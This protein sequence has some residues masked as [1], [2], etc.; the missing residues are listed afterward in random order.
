ML[1]Q[2]PSCR[3][4]YR[5]DDNAVKIPN[6]T[7]RC[8]RCRHIFVLGSKAAPSWSRE[9]SNATTA[10]RKQD[11]EE[12]GELTFS[13]PSSQGKPEKE[14]RNK[15]DFR[16]PDPKETQA[17]RNPRQD[18]LESQPLQTEEP[19]FPARDNLSLDEAQN[20]PWRV[21]DNHHPPEDANPSSGE[22]GSTSS[23]R[24]AEEE[25]FEI[26]QERR[27]HPVDAASREVATD[28]G[29]ATKPR[30]SASEEIETLMT[31][32]RK[33]E[34][35]LSVLPYMSLFCCLLLFYS[36]LTFINQARP[37]TVEPFLKAI[38]WLGS[39]IFKNNHLRL[40]I[41]VKLSRPSF[42]P[43]PGNREVFL[44]SGVALNHNPIG[45]RGIQLEGNI[46][47]ADGKEI[48]RQTIWVGNAISSK[49]I[50]GMTA[51]EISDI[52]KLPPLKRFEIAPEESI[53]FAIVFFRPSREIK[54]FSCRV[55]ST[56]HV[57]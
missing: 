4:T 43:I 34:N 31:D 56:D 57:T 40:G 39:S 6:P 42:Q 3:T 45:V 14:S 51:Q 53:T 48:E 28:F 7:F 12:N 10:S 36:V 47:N 29:A 1:V 9:T 32:N 15:A 26:P 19:S 38:P 8:S 22:V 35:P 25:S 21:A 5:V 17:V 37:Q 54:Y 16:F 55:L 11:N 30:R 20:Q 24:P 46:Y 49:I 52:Q 23:S 13:F 41:D 18:A 33:Q 27:P 44:I 50:R 2:C